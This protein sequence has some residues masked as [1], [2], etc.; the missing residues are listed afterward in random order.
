MNELSRDFLINADSI[1]G[2][3]VLLTTPLLLYWIFHSYW[4]GSF[5]K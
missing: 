5:R 4:N 1:I 2:I 3:I